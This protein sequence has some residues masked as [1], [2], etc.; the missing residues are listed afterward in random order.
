MYGL[1]FIIAKGIMP[2]TIKP[3]A[4]LAL[5]TVIT[6][7]LFW[8]TASFFPAEKVQKKHL[9]YL[10][11]CSF[12]GVVFNQFLFLAGLNLTTPIN[13]SLILTMNPIA[14]F[15]FAAIILKEEISLLKGIG[16]TVGLSGVVILILQEGVP[17]L[18]SSTFL[19]NLFSL[20]S[21]TSWALYT[22]LIKRMLEKY[23]PVTVMKWTFLFGGMASMFM[24][25]PDLSRTSWSGFTAFGWASLAFVIFFATYLGYLLI[26]SGLKNLSPTVV[27]VYTYVQPLIATLVSSIIGQDRL[28]A[29]KVISAI[30]IFTGVYLVSKKQKSLSVQP[31][32]LTTSPDSSYQDPHLPRHKL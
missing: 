26:S 9:L 1:N 15:I 12:L 11:C 6:A 28:T 21:T 3:V 19:G 24:G 27:S 20:L 22:V 30:L 8:L 4:L 10:F 25:F 32:N 18:G 29:V 31:V 23:H 5:R 14:A 2:V 13:S 16:L 17:E 7:G